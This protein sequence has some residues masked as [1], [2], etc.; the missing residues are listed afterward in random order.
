MTLVV[1]K[2]IVKGEVRYEITVVG[3]NATS[4]R[5]EREVML[6][7]IREAVAKHR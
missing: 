7:A 1:T 6:R 5:E 4:N 2:N 3:E